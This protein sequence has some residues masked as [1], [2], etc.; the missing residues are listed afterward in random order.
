AG[1]GLPRRRAAADAPHLRQPPPREDPAG[2]AHSTLPA[3]VQRKTA[4]LSPKQAI[5][6][7][8]DFQDF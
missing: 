3:V 5:P 8:D 1:R 7:E 2:R 4:K 6:L